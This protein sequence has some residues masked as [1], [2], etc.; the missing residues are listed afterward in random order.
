M[1]DEIH[2]SDVALIREGSI[3]PAQGLTVVTGETGA[4]KTALLSACKL[5]CGERADASF[6]REG[7][8]SLVA[9]GRFFVGEAGDEVVASR[10]VGADGR[11]RVTINGSMASVGELAETLG[12]TVDLCGQHEHQ[13]LLKPANHRG[14][15]DA[16]AGEAVAGR[17]A[18][19]QQAYAA[20]ADA[21][22]ELRRIE[23]ARQSSSAKLEEARFI[24]RRIDAVDPEAGEYE[25]LSESLAHAEH[26][27]ALAVAASTA[28][29]ALADDEGAIDNTHKAASALQAMAGIDKKLG[30]IADGLRE[31]A[32]VLEDAANEALRY[33]DSIE[34]DPDQLA[35]NQERIAAMQGLMREY[36]PRME[37]V[38][39]RREEAA[40]LVSMVDDS[41]QREAAAR[42]ALEKAEADLGALADA[43]DEVRLKAAP[44]FTDAV[45]GK[46]A[47]LEMNDAEIECLVERQER[48][49]WTKEGPSKIEFLFRAGKGLSARPLARIASGGEISRVM[50]AIK[51]VLGDVDNVETLIFDEVDAGVG[52]TTAVALASV[53]SELA[54]THQ[55]IVVTH[56]PQVAVAGDVHYEVRKQAPSNVQNDAEES[57]MP[58]TMLERIEGADRIR[59]IARMLSGDATETSL[60][61]A[62]ELLD[63]AMRKAKG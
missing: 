19:Y 35:L 63:D 29:S 54:E 2:I 30:D 1:I 12:S 23:E 53:L 11:S 40:E 49:L 33:R 55:V 22:A 9:E 25:R 60:K 20:A 39:A 18:E 28:H 3:A 24:V 6:V 51:A 45:N 8:A 27:E 26:A 32:Y 44:D 41:D 15:L 17:L 42:S 34:Y 37:D 36:G 38:I 62:E 21:A 59:E 56:L 58:E 46:L 31:A 5:L 47:C 57:A 4:G 48:D 10:R 50:L 61:H 16:W 52:G 14:M 13:R 43:L 7:S